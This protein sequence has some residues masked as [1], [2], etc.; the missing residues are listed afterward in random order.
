MGINNAGGGSKMKNKPDGYARFSGC[1]K[2]EPYILENGH[3]VP[4]APPK[5]KQKILHFCDTCFWG[6]W[7]KRTK[8]C[9]TCSQSHRE[10]WLDRFHPTIKNKF[11]R[12]LMI[13]ILRKEIKDNRKKLSA[14]LKK[15]VF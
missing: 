11:Y 3:A 5:K 2:P 1:D 8:V 12:G 15:G 9:R 10:N 7:G 6:N 14:L 13:E 4:W